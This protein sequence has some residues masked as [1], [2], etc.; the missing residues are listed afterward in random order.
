MSDAHWLCICFFVFAVSH[1]LHLKGFFYFLG[2]RRGN[3]PDP[4]GRLSPTGYSLPRLA[5]GPRPA[6]L[7]AAARTACAAFLP[8]IT[9][10]KKTGS[11]AARSGGR[12]DS[13]TDSLPLWSGATDGRTAGRTAG[14]RLENA[15]DKLFS[16]INY[17]KSWKIVNCVLTFIIICIL[18]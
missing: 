8:I 3:L 11:R 14:T 4:P 17:K 13:R 1:S 2:G 9:A 15:R 16:N 10:W 6:L 7:I 12:T 18:L 5:A